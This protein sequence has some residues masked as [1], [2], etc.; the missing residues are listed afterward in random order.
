[1]PRRLAAAIVA[2]AAIV[3][4]ASCSASG[5]TT[6][7]VSTPPALSAGVPAP[8]TGME[9]GPT[10][11]PRACPTGQV[12]TAEQVMVAALEEV[13]SYRGTD[14]DPAAAAA[15]RAAELLTPTYRAAAAGSWSMLA[16]ITGSQ[17]AQW[18]ASGATVVASARLLSDE[19]PPDTAA[20]TARVARVTQT[21]T[22]TADQ[23][24][25]MT[26]WVVAVAG[27]PSGWQLDTIT[28]QQ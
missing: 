23:L 24:A 4:L 21:V 3:A 9:P 18:T 1:M 17:W 7:S 22:P 10:S 26:V 11:Q 14:R 20:T 5:E 6:N 8:R 2:G 13:F 19:H 27:G 12:C 15:D 28:T 16:A 25:P